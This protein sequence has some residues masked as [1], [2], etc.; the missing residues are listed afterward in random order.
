M[1][2]RMDVGDDVLKRV[3]EAEPDVIIVD[4]E[5]PDSGI[6]EDISAISRHQP[7]PIVMFAGS[8]DSE[9]IQAAI[10]ARVSA[11]VMNGLSDRRIKPIVELAIARFHEFNALR[12]E[13]A[14][15][16]RD[17]AERKIVERAKG[18]LMKSKGLSE[19]QAYKA[20]RKAAMDRNQRLGEVARNVIAV[21]E[22]LT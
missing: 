13:L 19:D 4:M 15:V 20:L 21:T 14:Q 5:A 2:A 7:K 18:I 16:K 3:S 12:T 17:L 6:L 8:S 11:F 10:R 1:V 22:L 9:M